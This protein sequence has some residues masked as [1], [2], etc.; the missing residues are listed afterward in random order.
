[1]E[2]EGWGKDC[3]LKWLLFQQVLGKLKDRNIPISTTTKLF[4]IARHDDI[5]ITD[6][7][8]FTLCLQYYNDI[9]TIIY[10]DEDKLK[11]H[12]IL[13]PKMVDT[14]LDRYRLKITFTKTFKCKNGDFSIDRKNMANLLDIDYRCFE[15]KSDHLSDDLV[16]PWDF[17]DELQ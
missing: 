4:K 9:G 8:E 3:P 14:L 5:G 17:N 2:M 13:D 10:F 1:M 6:L 16:G 7:N 15:H 11:D 12:V